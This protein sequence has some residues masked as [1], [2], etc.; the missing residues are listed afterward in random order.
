FTQSRALRALGRFERRE[1]VTDLLAFLVPTSPADQ[2]GT[3]RV[4]EAAQAVAQSL[5][6]DPWPSDPSN[7]QVQGA[8]DALAQVGTTEVGVSLGAIARAI[9]RLPYTTAPQVHAAD[10]FL[11][12][13]MRR[14]DPDSSQ[15]EALA[16][17]TRGVE[18]LARIDDRLAPL[19]SDT[20]DW[21]RRILLGIRSKYDPATRINALAALVAARG[22][23]A[24]TLRA[25]V[26]KDGP[27]DL[28]RLA[29]VVLGGAGAPVVAT[30]RTTLLTSLLSDSSATVRLEAV[31]AWARREAPVNGCARLFDALK[32]SNTGVVLAAVDALGDACRNDQNV[33]DRLMVEARTPP[34]TAWHRESHALVALARRAPARVVIPLL[35]GFISHPAWQVRMYAARA[36]ALINETSALERLGYDPIDNVREAALGPLRRL[37]GDEAEPYFLAA[38]TR[39]DHQLLRTAALELKGLTPTSALGK[40][41]ADALRRVTAEGQETSRD[42]RLALLERLREIGAADQAGEVIPLLEDFDLPVALAAAQLLQQWAGKSFDIDPHPRP[43]VIA[44][45]APGNPA[46]IKLGNGRILHI[47]LLTEVAPLSTGRFAHLAAAGYYNGLTFHRVLPNFVAQGGSPGANEYSGDGPYLRDEISLA[48]NR[49]GS[50]GLSTRGRDTGDAQ[51]FVNLVDSPRLDFEYTVFGDVIDSD[52]NLLATIE[53]GERIVSVT[54]D[55]DEDDKKPHP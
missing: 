26:D 34:P 51:F 10:A 14:I 23:D 54:F 19:S 6:G 22:V 20:I 2:D 9:G 11:L 17:I 16:E 35:G 52:L 50:V 30:E 38:L 43:R 53:E 12:A 13:A 7:Q 45:S 47:Q 3:R 36:A 4:A 55:T 24:D 18:S 1:L 28:K 5:R 21:L 46:R 15:R 40:A 37:K 49:L 41:L 25:A 8:F 31:R 29:A 33:T 32:D 27:V 42:T 39:P 48:P 44:A